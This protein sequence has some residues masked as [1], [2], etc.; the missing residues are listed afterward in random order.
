MSFNII[1]PNQGNSPGIFPAQNNENFRRLK[2]I[3][4][5]EHDFTDSTSLSQGIHK[6]C[7]FINRATP[8]GLP[9]GNGVLYSQADG[10]GASQLHWYNGASDVT[11]TPGVQVLTGTANI[12]PLSEITI[13]PDPGY[14]YQAYY[15]LGANGLAVIS[16]ATAVHYSNNVNVIEAA[17]TANI[18]IFYSGNGLKV[19]NIAN[20][21]SPIATLWTL[22]IIRTG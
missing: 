18:Q 10:S 12:G 21:G 20:S 14:P 7:T 6:Q 8:V 4:N 13:F 17:Q 3:I 1:V 11:I 15:F 16:A 9:A 22:E 5:A 2:A 19:K